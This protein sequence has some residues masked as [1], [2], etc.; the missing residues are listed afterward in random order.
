[1]YVYLL[2]EKP[3][4]EIDPPNEGWLKIKFNVDFF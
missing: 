1:M 2:I 4:F 3:E